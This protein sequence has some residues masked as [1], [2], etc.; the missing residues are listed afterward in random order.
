MGKGTRE[1]WEAWGGHGMATFNWMVREGLV[2]KQEG[3]EQEPSKKRE[4]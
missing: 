2:D 1:F 4:P 3:R